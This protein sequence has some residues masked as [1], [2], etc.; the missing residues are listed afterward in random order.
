MPTVVMVPRPVT[1]VSR[2]PQPRAV[3]EHHHMVMLPAVC[4][5]QLVHVWLRL[6]PV[7]PLVLLGRQRYADQPMQKGKVIVGLLLPAFVP[8]H[9]HMKRKM[10]AFGLT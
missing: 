1:V 3:K 6:G 5:V 2:K 7:Y 10:P 4:L 9:P 8:S